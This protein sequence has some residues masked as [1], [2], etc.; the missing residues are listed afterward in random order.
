MALTRE[1]GLQDVPV[2]KAAWREHCLWPLGVIDEGRSK[3]DIHEVGSRSRGSPYLRASLLLVRNGVSPGHSEGVRIIH[4]A[5]I[6]CRIH[7]SCGCAIP[8]SPRLH[9]VQ[10]V[11]ACLLVYV[12]PTVGNRSLNSPEST[13]LGTY[14]RPG[15][16]T[17]FTDHYSITSGAQTEK[18]TS[19]APCSSCSP[20]S[21]ETRAYD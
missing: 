19:L 8:F 7:F 10:R 21:V 6:L 11:R 5:P 4:T 14:A 20:S 18:P 1:Q 17:H 16:A 12:M 9:R 3:G 13:G 15:G 2:A